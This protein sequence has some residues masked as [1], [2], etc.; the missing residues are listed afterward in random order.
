MQ[1]CRL[2][3]I[4]G[5]GIVLGFMLSIAITASAQTHVTASVEASAGATIETSFNQPRPDV[6]LN[7]QRWKPATKI[8]QITGA[9]VSKLSLTARFDFGTMDDAPVSV[10][11]VSGRNYTNLYPQVRSYIGTLRQIELGGSYRVLP[12]ISA[13]VNFLRYTLK[14][15][16]ELLH[17]T[18][19]D[20]AGWIQAYTD[21]NRYQGLGFGPTAEYHNDKTS[22]KGGLLWYPNIQRHW[23]SHE[24]S[25]GQVYVNN[26]DVDGHTSGLQLTGKVSYQLIKHLDVSFSYRFQRFATNWSGS[27]KA[28]AD[29]QVMYLKVLTPAF[30][31]N[32]KF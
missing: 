11:A 25:L 6:V 5:L 2:T 3:R 9:P 32:V 17:A 27:D 7:G 21:T 23:D 26:V 19:I 15:D 8:L 28:M 13:T 10:D 16:E 22:F 4:V 1:N 14:N 29:D 20:G 12:H 30:G 31:F 18:T 24:N